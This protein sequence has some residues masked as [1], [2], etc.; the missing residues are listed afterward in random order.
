MIRPAQGA[1]ALL[2]ERLL[3]PEAELDRL[4][5]ALLARHPA[6][7]VPIGLLTKNLTASGGNWVIMRLFDQ[8]VATGRAEVHVFVVPEEGAHVGVLRNLVACRRRYAAAASVKPALRAVRPA[9]FDVL[10]STSRR[11][12]DFVADLSHPAHVHLFQMIEAWRTMSSDALLDRCRRLGY[13]GPGE[14]VAL[15][16]ELGIPEDLRYLEQVG[17]T[18]RFVAVSEF[19]ASAAASLGAAKD[20]DVRVPD[21]HV[22]RSGPAL[23]RNIDALFFL[24]GQVHKGDDLTLQV[25]NA[26]PDASRVTVVVAPGASRAARRLHRRPGLVTASDPPPPVLAD[27]LAS[28][29]VVVH[30]SL[31]EGGGSIPVEALALACQ[32]VASRTG[33]L[34]RAESGGPL[35]VIERHDPELYLAEV[36]RRLGAR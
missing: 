33:W 28:S 4:G 12:L 22:K 6:R 15:V 21:R 18:R 20:V 3:G 31:C 5:D 14:S 30:P 25:A 11:T 19:L 9:D 17:A 23:P 13:P 7:T 24:R 32:V 27:L 16:R 35:S 36:L 29:R 1:N 8:L 2:L 10:L 26:M 34:L